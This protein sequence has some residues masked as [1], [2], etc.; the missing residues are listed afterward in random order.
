MKYP[1]RLIVLIICVLMTAG[2]ASNP[3]LTEKIS[4]TKIC[5]QGVCE[6]INNVASSKHLLNSI[7][8]LLT[9]N[10]S[11]PAHICRANEDSGECRKK[12]VCYLVVGGIMPGNGCAK[13]FIV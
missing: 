10:A 5:H 2:C 9:L 8:Q 1:G 13:D 11:S 12:D 4:G 3:S 6:P 7:H